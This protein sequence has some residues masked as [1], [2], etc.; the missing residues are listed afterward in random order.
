MYHVPCQAISMITILDVSFLY[1]PSGLLVFSGLRVTTLQNF[2][3]NLCVHEFEFNQP[4]L[5]LSPSPQ[6]LEL[7]FTAKLSLTY[8]IYVMAELN[9]FSRATGETSL[10]N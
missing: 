10:A 8:I 9:A 2:I 7:E 3:S 6:P 4:Y 1:A 5:R